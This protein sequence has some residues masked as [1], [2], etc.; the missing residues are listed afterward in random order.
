MWN[1]LKKC[2]QIDV[3]GIKIITCMTSK[4]VECCF[5]ACMHKIALTLFMDKAFWCK[6]MLVQ[7]LQLTE[8]CADMLAFQQIWPGI[9]L[10]WSLSNL[11]SSF[12]ECLNLLAKSCK[13][14]YN[15]SP[16]CGEVNVFHH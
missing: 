13:D 1:Q 6:S 4:G 10:F 2:V 16:C 3:D 5:C 11:D 14:I 7:S 9:C 12:L 8:I 15:G